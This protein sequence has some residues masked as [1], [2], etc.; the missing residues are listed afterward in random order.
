MPETLT[1]LH[2]TIRQAFGIQAD[3]RIQFMDPEFNNEFMNVTS[4][5]DIQDRSTMKLVYM[6]N[7]VGVSPSSPMQN[8]CSPS[9]SSRSPVSSQTLDSVSP[10]PPSSS[11]DS[12]NTIILSHS[13]S[14]MRARA[15]PREFS[16]LRFQYDVELQL[17]RGNESF[18]ET[19]SLLKIPP[20]LKS[21]IS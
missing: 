8:A 11:T 7:N 14:E 15:W 19:G 3:F 18:R 16:I 13:D 17:Q 21:K 12:D 4:V 6:L 2:N 20:G 10:L 5:H 9:L 1:D